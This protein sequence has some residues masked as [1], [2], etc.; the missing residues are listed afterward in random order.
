M[1]FYCQFK[2]LVSRRGLT[3]IHEIFCKAIFSTLKLHEQRQ[4]F[5]YLIILMSLLYSKYRLRFWD[6]IS[7]SFIADSGKW[8]VL[9]R[10]TP[11][12]ANVHLCKG[13]CETVV[14][15]CIDG[16]LPK[17]FIFGGLSNTPTEH[18]CCCF[19]KLTW[20]QMCFVYPKVLSSSVTSKSKS[21]CSAFQESSVLDWNKV[22]CQD[23]IV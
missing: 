11:L 14:G 19:T 10:C 7:A 15:S 18:I 23:Y 3:W 22:M 8:L 16:N 4:M 12:T 6:S 21:E 13:G 2:Q 20:S 5:P 17:S 1:N 9:L